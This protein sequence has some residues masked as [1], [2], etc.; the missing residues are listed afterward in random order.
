MPKPGDLKMS[1][2]ILSSVST[3]ITPRSRLYSLE[4][5]GVGTSLVESLSS[6]LIRLAQEHCVLPKKLIMGEIAPIILGEEYQ[7]E[8]LKKSV[9]SIFGYRDAKPA[10]NGMGN[11]TR[12]LTDALEQ[13]T[14]RQDLKYLSC[15][16][17]KKVIQEQGLFRKHQAWCP[18]CFEQWHQSGNT[19]YEPL[20]W[21]F[22]DIPY[23]QQ[24]HCLLIDTCPHCGSRQKAIANN[25]RLG[26]CDHCKKWLGQ[27]DCQG[28][29]IV[30]NEKQTLIQTGIGELVATAPF[31]ADA[32]VLTDLI[33]KVQV[34]TLSHCLPSKYKYHSNKSITLGKILSHIQARL[35]QDENLLYDLTRYLIPTC[36]H[37]E[38]SLSQ[39]FKEDLLYLMKLLG[40]D[41][42]IKF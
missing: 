10:I 20:I 34:I 42:K 27:K 38:I 15:L 31:L 39:L 37:V 5:V 19:L 8:M 16:T 12:S 41:L 13:L 33:L 17:Y 6:Y 29:S 25:R 26:F 14:L 11:M 1:D 9:S 4:P 7:P 30:N 32:P 28:S 18:K 3:G 35:K 23:C 2:R 36:S 21:S 40:I 22:K 24:H